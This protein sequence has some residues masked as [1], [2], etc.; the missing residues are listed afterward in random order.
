MK[1]LAALLMLT[2]CVQAFPASAP[3]QP[4]ISKLDALTVALLEDGDT[5]C[6]GTWISESTILTA[7]HCVTNDLYA[8]LGITA[9]GSALDYKLFDGT[10]HHAKVAQISGRYDLALLQAEM[11]MPKHAVVKIGATPAVGQAIF[12]VG[13]PLGLEWSYIPGTVSAIRNE[14]HVKRLQLSMALAPG[15]SGAA[16]FN[17]QEELVG[18]VLSGSRQYAIHFAIDQKPISS[19]LATGE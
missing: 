18:V 16:I 3:V 7:K 4:D 17:A 19:F 13:H 11:P 8:F 6:A 14:K 9:V 5:V 2:G 10:V 15:D 1:K 12:C